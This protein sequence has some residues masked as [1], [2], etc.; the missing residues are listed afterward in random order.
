M[1]YGYKIRDVEREEQAPYWQFPG[2]Y[3]N[4]LWFSGSTEGQMAQR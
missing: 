1:E 4:I 2:N 3:P